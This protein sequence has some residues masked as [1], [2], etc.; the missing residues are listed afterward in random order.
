VQ[1]A[2]AT[3]VV[4]HPY[5][6]AHPDH[7][8]T[9]FATHAALRLLNKNGF[10]PPALFEMALHPSLDSAAKIPEFLSA[11][12][13]ETT[14]LMLDAKARTLKANMFDCFQSQKKSLLDSPLGPEKFRSPGDYD[15][16]QPPCEG[17]LHY[18][19]FEWAPSP[20]EWQQNA[21]VAWTTLFPA[22]LQAN[23]SH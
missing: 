3:I 12:D 8:A 1:Q 21:R 17:K 18:E 4:T 22:S 11:H 5:E 2:G 6:G 10:R 23:N 14:I 15:F 13:R 7:D 16:N 19:N 9:A 20:A